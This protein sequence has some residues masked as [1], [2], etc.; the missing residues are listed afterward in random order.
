I[1]TVMVSV[2]HLITYVFLFISL[3]F[4][5]FLLITYFESRLFM[6]EEDK[7]IAR[8]V[9]K[10][11]SVSIIVACW[12]EEETV[13]KTIH[14]ILNLDYRKDKLKI[15]AIDDG[16]TDSTWQKLLK[17]ENHPQ[18]KIYKKENGG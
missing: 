17:F 3:N 4:E 18:V 14:Y 1:L 11:P 9:K 8:G 2:T 10:F 13:S 16:S 15:M 5:V 12:N 6:K 7:V